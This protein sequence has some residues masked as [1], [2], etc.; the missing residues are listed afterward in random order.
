MSPDPDPP[1]AAVV[2]PHG[3]DA[4]PSWAT[5]EIAIDFPALPPIVAR[6]REAF[7]GAAADSDVVLTGDVPLTAEQ[8]Q[9]GGSLPVEVPVWRICARCAGR[10]EIWDEACGQCA[11][12]GHGVVRR[13]VDVAVPAGVRD[14][15]WMSF[16]LA[17]HLAP[18]TRVHLRVA[19][20]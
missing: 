6:M 9:R 3:C 14:G 10:G 1:P 17:T 12:Q 16:D 7:L 4:R 13:T 5:D 11:G 19:I 20:R 18:A 15:T 2:S 8:A